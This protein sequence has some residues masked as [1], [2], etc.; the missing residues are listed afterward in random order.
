MKLTTENKPFENKVALVTGGTSGIG[1]TTSLA[2]AKAG[3]KV[4]VSGRREKEGNYVVSLIKKIG[5]DGTFVKTDVSSEAD[6]ETLVGKTLSTYGR[7]DV[8]FNNAGVEGEPAKRTHEQSVAN[9]RTVMDINV[10][11]VLVAMKHEI[12]AMLKKGGGSIVNNSSVGGLVGFPGASVYVA[13][14]HA[15]MGLT[16]SAALEYAR[17]GIRVNAVSPGPIETPMLDRFMGQFGPDAERQFL[18]ALPIGR[19]GRP[20]EIAEAVLWLCSDKA[21]FVTGQSLTV[22]GG[23]TAQ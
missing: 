9:Y 11:G 3:A 10:L 13:S 17:E 5:G 23:F 14:K 16:R 22:D 20:E 7:L 8:A 6:V 21:S 1:L 18:A 12:S 19:K 2:F 15:V 4:V